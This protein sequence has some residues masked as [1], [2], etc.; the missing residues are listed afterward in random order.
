[1]CERCSDIVRKENSINEIVISY[2][3]LFDKAIEIGAGVPECCHRGEDYGYM[4]IF[5]SGSSRFGIFS[6][7]CFPGDSASLS[8]YS[9]AAL[10]SAHPCHF[11][12]WAR[13]EWIWFCILLVMAM[14]FF[15]SSIAWYSAYCMSVVETHGTIAGVIFTNDPISIVFG[16]VGGVNNL[17]RPAGVPLIIA[18]TNS[19]I[20]AC[21]NT[22]SSGLRWLAAPDRILRMVVKCCA[23]AGTIAIDVP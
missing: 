7:S 12:H 8:L 15:C 2:S 23:V 3:E 13:Q 14:S 21:M 19:W 5:E 10:L 20:C 16:A 17:I 18:S 4:N 11:R 6:Q 1:M 22:G 9:G